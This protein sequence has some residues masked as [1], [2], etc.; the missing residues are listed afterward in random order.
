MNYPAFTNQ[1]LTMMY[2]AIRAALAADVAFKNDGGDPPFRVLDTPEWKKH[3]AE[4]EA[5]MRT[6]GMFFEVIEWSE[7]QG[8]L[9][10]RAP[11]NRSTACAYCEPMCATT[12]TQLADRLKRKRQLPD[13]P[14]IACSKCGSTDWAT[15]E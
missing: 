10:M 3:A 7:G 11:E 2:A 4:L 14:I 5:E 9:P 6:R 13:V 8:K 12:E 15:H 1:S